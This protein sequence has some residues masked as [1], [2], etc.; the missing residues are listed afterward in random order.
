MLVVSSLNEVEGSAGACERY[1]LVLVR[2]ER[3]KR[4]VFLAQLCD[5][6]R[7]RS[8][9][10]RRREDRREGMAF[11]CGLPGIVAESQTGVDIR[12]RPMGVMFREGLTAA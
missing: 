4:C 5:S 11:V 8:R 10:E 9:E 2:M 12:V 1:L 7:A 3:G 6:A